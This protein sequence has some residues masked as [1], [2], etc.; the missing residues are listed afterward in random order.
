M[1]LISAPP[2]V[3]SGSDPVGCHLL[4]SSEDNE[5][6]GTT[7]M[8]QKA[9]D[10]DLAE[11]RCKGRGRTSPWTWGSKGQY[12]ERAKLLHAGPTASPSLGPACSKKQ[13]H[14]PRL[15][16]LWAQG[17]RLCSGP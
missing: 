15:G 16:A 4:K 9:G 1:Q 10:C 7:R 14:P 8:T 17:Q 3:G 6:T 12:R 5:F 11:T 13:P 2:A